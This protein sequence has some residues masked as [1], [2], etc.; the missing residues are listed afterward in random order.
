M[1]YDSTCSVAFLLPDSTTRVTKCKRIVCVRKVM[2][3]KWEARHTKACHCTH[4]QIVH[5]YNTT[6]TILYYIYYNTTIAIIL[7]YH[8]TII[9]LLLLLSK[10]TTDTTISSQNHTPTTNSNAWLHTKQTIQFSC[11]AVHSPEANNEESLRHI[12]CN[13]Q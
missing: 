7:L 1:G 13:E 12:M 4:T 6:T 11:S 2:Q 5:Y 8:Y 3:E 10:T 9:L